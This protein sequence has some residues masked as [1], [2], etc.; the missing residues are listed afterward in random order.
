MSALANLAAALG[1]LDQALDDLV[2][3]GTRKLVEQRMQAALS[4]RYNRRPAVAGDIDTGGSHSDAPTADLSDLES[5]ILGFVG[6]NA[7]RTVRAIR[8][9]VRR[10]ASD[11]GRAVVR[12]EAAGIIE[13]RGSRTHGRFY[14][15]RETRGNGQETRRKRSSHSRG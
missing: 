9:G 10:R 1:A 13:N 4:A 12:L 6:T 8:E 14:L 11:V 15:S 2:E 5:R 7:G 3:P